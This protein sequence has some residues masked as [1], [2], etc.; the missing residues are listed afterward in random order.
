MKE[1]IKKVLP[2]VAGTAMVLASNV[3]ASAE[4]GGVAEIITTTAT[5]LKSDATTVIT[6]GV[7]IGVVF[8]GAK[9]LWSKFKSMAR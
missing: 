6:A 3:V 8:F 5:S 1:K 4:S 9:L 2:A 7:G